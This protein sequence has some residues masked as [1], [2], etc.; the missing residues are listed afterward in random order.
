M[1]KDEIII[2][3]ELIQVNSGQVTTIL[4]KDTKELQDKLVAFKPEVVQQYKERKLDIYMDTKYFTA[5]TETTNVKGGAYSV[6]PGYYSVAGKA[7]TTT[8]STTYSTSDWFLVQGNKRISELQFANITNNTAIIEAYKQADSDMDKLRHKKAVASRVTMGVVGV[9]ATGLGV[10]FLMKGIEA[11]ID[12]QTAVKVFGIFGG[13][14]F[15]IMGG[16]MVIMSVA[17]RTKKF[18]NY[19]K[20]NADDLNLISF[21]EAERTI[22]TYNQNLKNLNQQCSNFLP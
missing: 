15:T 21:T 3:G 18:E 8:I 11:D 17:N 1:T 12:T 6:F 9:P 20:Y 19:L 13:A 22:I 2:Y 16:T 5:T 14:V 10:F 7:E 4:V